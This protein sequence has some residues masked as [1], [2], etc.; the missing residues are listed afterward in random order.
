MFEDKFKGSTVILA[1]WV[2]DRIK[3]DDVKTA[4]IMHDGD[5]VTFVLK[6]VT[7]KPKITLW[8]NFEKG[9]GGYSFAK[10]F[11]HAVA[12]TV[13]FK[14]FYVEP[15]KAGNRKE[16]KLHRFKSITTE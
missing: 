8:F 15:N 6:N 1:E 16:A 2:S 12:F 13:D 9:F 3:S 7:D 14:W 5:K 11:E 4:Y 10:E